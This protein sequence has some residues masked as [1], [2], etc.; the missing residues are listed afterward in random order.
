M[1]ARPLPSP[2]ALPPR[3]RVDALRQLSLFGLAYLGYQAVRGLVATDGPRPF[4]DATRIIDTE[5]ALHV[6]VEPRLQAWVTSHAHWLLVLADWSYLNAHVPLTGAALAFLYL[7]RRESFRPVRDMF[8]IAMLLGLIGYAVYPTAPPRLMPQWGF[9]DSIRQFT[10]IDAQRGAAALLLNPYAAVP[11]MH[12]CVAVMTAGSMIGV[13]RRRVTRLLWA[14]YPAWIVVVVLVTANHYLTDVALGA[15][16]A[17]ISALIATRRPAR[18]RPRTLALARL[19][20]G[21]RFSDPR[22]PIN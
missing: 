10:G 16:T 12:V 1:R 13:A 3:G 7:R 9:S 20:A 19:G 17:G 14:A 22:Q 4:V 15:L 2:L 18:A 11:S 8:L 21:D 5:R 6:F